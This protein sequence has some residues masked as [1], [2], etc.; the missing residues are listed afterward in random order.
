MSF[1]AGAMIGCF[2]GVMIMAMVQI[3]KDDDGI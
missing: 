1:I 3:S 2:L